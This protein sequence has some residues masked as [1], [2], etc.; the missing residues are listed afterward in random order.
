MA[1]YD[2][3]GKKILITGASRGIGRSLAVTL[4]KAGAL[5]YALSN[6]R[7]DLETLVQEHPSIRTICVDLSDWEATRT[8]IEK[9]DALDGLVNNA[10]L[11]FGAKPSLEQ[12]KEE[13]DQMIAV[14]LRAPM[15]ITQVVAGK[16]I[17]AGKG[18]TIVNMSSVNSIRAI[19]GA[20]GYAMC[21]AGLDV[22]TKH[23]AF[24]L[25]K[26]NIRVNS[27][28]PTVVKTDL[29]KETVSQEALNSFNAI[30][31]LGRSA[32]IAEIIGP[33]MYLLSDA[34]SMVTGTMHSVDGG[35]SIGLT[36]Q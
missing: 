36:L 6:V 4:C 10:V 28:L 32:E 25:G 27:V 8:E 18:G 21:K 20:M 30:T 3:S 22:M 26:Y 23:Y 1:S 19:S 9:L 34:S 13:F 31:S 17:E 24:D 14:N 35:M 12:S 2:F 7:E 33:I 15:N 5:V 16:M 29:V 11:Y